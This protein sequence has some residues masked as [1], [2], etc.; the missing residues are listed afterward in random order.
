[1]IKG[2]FRTSFVPTRAVKGK[3]LIYAFDRK[4]NVRTASHQND[5]DLS[6][7]RQA[8]TWSQETIKGV[9]RERLQ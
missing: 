3:A 1:M 8:F 9:N 5:V 4:A 2:G 7:F 6:N